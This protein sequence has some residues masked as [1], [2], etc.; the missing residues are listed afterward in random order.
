[1]ILHLPN[2]HEPITEKFMK[3]VLIKKSELN[4]PVIHNFDHL[5]DLVRGR[6]QRPLREPA[7]IGIDDNNVEFL[8]TND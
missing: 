4:N 7:K 1:M 2:K 3:R 8:A 6:R 5:C